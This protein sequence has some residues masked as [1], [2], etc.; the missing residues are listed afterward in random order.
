MIVVRCCIQAARHRIRREFEQLC[1]R[2][3]VWSTYDLHTGQWFWTKMDSIF[4]G[5]LIRGSDL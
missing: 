4:R 2:S 5:R 1:S 3:S